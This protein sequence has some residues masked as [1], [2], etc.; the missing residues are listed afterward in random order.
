MT[1]RANKEC[2]LKSYHLHSTAIAMA[3]LF[4][5]C[6]TRNFNSSEKSLQVRG[7]STAFAH[8]FY[9]LPGTNTA[10]VSSGFFEKRSKWLQ[11][12]ENESTTL[13]CFSDARGLQYEDS[14]IGADKKVL[15]RAMHKRPV[16]VGEFY[17]SLYES[18]TTIFLKKQLEQRDEI[19]LNTFTHG[20]NTV[21]N[22]EKDTKTKTTLEK[23]YGS[24][25]SS[26]SHAEYLE[27]IEGSK[28]DTRVLLFLESVKRQDYLKMAQVLFEN[29]EE[30]VLNSQKI[31][32]EVWA[33]VTS[34]LSNQPSVTAKKTFDTLGKAWGVVQSLALKK[35]VNRLPKNETEVLSV[36][37]NFATKAQLEKLKAGVLYASIVRQMV[38]KGAVTESG[39][40]GFAADLVKNISTVQVTE[41]GADDPTV[42][43]G[44]EH[45]L[46]VL[47]SEANRAALV[48]ILEK[49]AAVD[50][51][52]TE[53]DAA[54]A[55]T[56]LN[57]LSDAKQALKP[58]LE[59][60]AEKF[61]ELLLSRNEFNGKL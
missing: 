44:V 46:E 2:G 10:S 7:G 21:I 25:L 13:V 57:R 19:E 22:S 5:S 39:F 41:T 40:N 36:S 6:K 12:A 60:N 29:K 15:F 52:M 1:L 58:E 3:A 27:Q 35:I 30:I 59:C 33:N 8:E 9:F 42:L 45:F 32:T 50:L 23:I 47:R 55:R 17:Q 34:V 43:K 26:P 31:A 49:N 20:F 24:F 18:N 48:K 61:P 28:I 51:Q 56:I 14:T 53:V 16:S 37:S 4:L 11:F 54:I 38:Q